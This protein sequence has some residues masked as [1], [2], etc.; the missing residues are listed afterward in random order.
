MHV[1]VRRRV[2]TG[3]LGGIHAPQDFVPVG[4][5]KLEKQRLNSCTSYN[6]KAVSVLPASLAEQ[7]H[8]IQAT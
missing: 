4:T 3:A 7:I 1:V 2:S 5:L 6:V 8:I